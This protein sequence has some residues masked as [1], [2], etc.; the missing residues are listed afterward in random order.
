MTQRNRA[1]IIGG[2]AAVLI[3]LTIKNAMEGR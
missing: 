1:L 2:L 3:Y